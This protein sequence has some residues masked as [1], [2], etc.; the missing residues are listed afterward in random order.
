MF[1]I[2]G[3]TISA[4]MGLLQAG[5]G[6]AIMRPMPTIA[7]AYMSTI[8][9]SGVVGRSCKDAGWLNPG[10]RLGDSKHA[11]QMVLGDNTR[12]CTVTF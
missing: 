12:S 10:M 2:S 4:K 3:G 7:A 5:A 1:R 8:P 9:G 11:F 6:H